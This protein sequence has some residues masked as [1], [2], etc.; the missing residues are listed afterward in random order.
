MCWLAARV[1]ARTCMR[2]CVRACVRAFALHACCIVCACTRHAF[3]TRLTLHVPCVP[4][5]THDLRAPLPIPCT[6]PLP[7]AGLLLPQGPA[8]GG[9]AASALPRQRRSLQVRRHGRSE[10]GL[11]CAASPA[12]AAVLP[13]GR[14]ACLPMWSLELPL[15]TLPGLA[16]C[17]RLPQQAASP[18]PPTLCA[19]P[20]PPPPHTHTP[21]P[22]GVLPPQAGNLLPAVFRRQGVV[23][24]SEGLAVAVDAGAPGAWLTVRER[25]ACSRVC[26]TPSGWRDPA[27]CLRAAPPKTQLASHRTSVLCVLHAQAQTCK[28]TSASERCERRRWLPRAACATPPAPAPRRRSATGVAAP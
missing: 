1:C 14:L 23:Q 5:C 12:A 3:A 21:P 10:R 17:V 20:P 16:W 15:P 27:R 6:S 7:A 22:V 25:A 13:R 26:A 9:P 2:A 18:S 28:A 4:A 19:P 24:L 8:A 11:G